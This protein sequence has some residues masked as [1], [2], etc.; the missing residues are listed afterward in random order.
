MSDKRVEI[1]LSI[2]LDNPVTDY[3]RVAIEAESAGFADVWLPDH[4]FLRDV[5]AAQALIAAST[6]RIR[7]GTSVLGAP[8]RHPAL[9]A[10]SAA[11]IDEIAGGGRVI[12]GLGTGGYEFPSHLHLKPKSPMSMLREAVA[13]I[14]GVMDGGADVDGTYFSAS[15]AKLIWQP[16]RVPIYLAARG[17]KM[18]ELAGEIA[19]GA[20]V[21]GVS[22]SYLG[23]VE[24]QLRTGAERVGRDPA[25]CEPV[26]LLDVE[27]DD[28]VDAALERLRGRTVVMAGGS[29]SDAMI[30]RY[31]L[32]PDEVARLRAA[33]ADPATEP[34]RF[35]TDDM[36]RAFCLVGP[37]DQVTAQL[38]EL[39]EF[40]FRRIIV[41][42]GEGNPERTR[43][44]V[45]AFSSVIEEVCS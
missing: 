21:H 42:L 23:Y 18:L 31:G 34:S 20:I 22:P 4:Y 26:L 44:M 8:L 28:D 14:H 36:V 3:V 5:V 15:D 29:Y 9:V 37:L 2:W 24:G 17:P 38:A 32:D 27:I 40:G 12:V 33:I 16:E 19:D 43:E 6:K 39:R 11:T 25:A 45:R 1:G 35:V 30:P 10:S 13:I 41:K 7:L